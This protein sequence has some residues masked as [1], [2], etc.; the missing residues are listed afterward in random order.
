MTEYGETK[1]PE[2]ILAEIS[3]LDKEL[4]SLNEEADQALK[5][6]QAGKISKK[7]KDE[8][9]NRV[10]SKEDEIKNRQYQLILSLGKEDLVTKVLTDRLEQEALKQI[11]AAEEEAEEM[12]EEEPLPGSLDQAVEDGFG[13]YPEDI[14]EIDQRLR[15]VM[16][17][18][19]KKYEG[20][21]I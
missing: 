15:A 14:D 16:E 1:I 18:L 12:G 20:R 13:F 2:I 5:D 4:M 10:Y 21:L 19:L 9:D 3:E 11:Q 17:A 7:E 8:I 6:F